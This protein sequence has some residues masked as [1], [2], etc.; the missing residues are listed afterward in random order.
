MYFRSPISCIVDRWAGGNLA[1]KTE[2]V[3]LQS[4]S[5]GNSINKDIFPIP[6]RVFFQ[7]RSVESAE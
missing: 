5:L 7:G 1:R 2:I 6:A 4:R 3:P